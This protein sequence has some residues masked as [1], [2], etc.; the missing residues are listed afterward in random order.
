[1]NRYFLGLNDKRIKE[2]ARILESEGKAVYDFETNLEKIERG[3][4]VIVSP[5]YKWK[6]EIISKLREGV[7]VFGSKVKDDH[8]KFLEK[9]RYVDLMSIEDFVIDNA[10]LT[11]ENFLVDLILNTDSSMYEQK[12]LILGNGRVAKALWYLFLKLGISF[13]VMMRREDEYNLSKL[14]ANNSYKFGEYESR[15]GQYD[16]VINTIPTCLFKDAS[17]FKE[18]CV[19]FE[20]ASVNCLEDAKGVKYVLC[21][22]LPAKYSPKSAGRLIMNVVKNT[23]KGE[24]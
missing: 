8:N 2:V 5:A 22:A 7:L 20:L 3:D 6:E 1:M 21:P 14:I 16:V 9:V 24:K 23:L 11:A 19:V 10:K 18:D 12:I 15:I 4:I 13:D 17:R